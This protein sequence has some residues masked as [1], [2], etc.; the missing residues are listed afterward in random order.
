[1]SQRSESP[2]DSRLDAL[3]ALALAGIL[4]VNIQSFV[5]SAGNPLGYLAPDAGLVDLV[6]YFLLGV[7][8]EYKFMPI[9]ALLFGAGFGFLWDK[10]ETKGL[11]APA[12]MRRRFSFLLAF[13]L[14]HGLLLY[15]GDITNLYAL[16]GFLLLR[17]ARSGPEQLALSVRRWWLLALA[18]TALLAA[19]SMQVFGPATPD[20]EQA[21]AML[22]SFHTY[23]TAGYL[24]Q[25][26][27]RA[28]DFLML[29]LSV[30]LGGQWIATL[31]LMLTGLYAQ[32]AGWLSLSAH[33]VAWRRIAWGGVL[34]G[35]PASL[36]SA[37]MVLG[38]ALAGPGMPAD[39]LRSLPLALVPAL[40]FAYVA[41]FLTHAPSWVVA[42]L[43]PAGRMPLSNYLL[44]SVVMGALLS[45]W[46][47]GWGAWMNTWQLALLGLA[48]V[49]VQWLVSA[50]WLRV[51][52]Q[53]PLEAWWRRLSYGA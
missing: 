20:E 8:V 6:V 7:L 49:F 17:H 19:L 13:G 45:G 10:L 53:G 46:G 18:A 43:A 51:R 22:A 25:L 37:W 26:H 34:V 52:N 1:M 12:V 36:I 4:Q 28:L 35:L 48:I 15:Y 33:P 50:A 5:W 21:Q 27:T 30:W 9:F 2:R 16:L 11:N 3:R 39:P 42:A 40:S 14:A 29:A 23:T 24:E 31:A 44:Q 32:R 47:L 38:D 41:M